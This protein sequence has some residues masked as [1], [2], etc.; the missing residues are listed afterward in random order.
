MGGGS[1][2][3]VRSDEER[4]LL[5]KEEGSTVVDEVEPASVGLMTLFG[6]GAVLFGM[7]GTSLPGMLQGTLYGD[8]DW[9]GKQ[10]K[11]MIV[12]H[13]VGLIVCLGTGTMLLPKLKA[14]AEEVK[15]KS[16]TSSSGVE[17]RWDTLKWTLTM[18]VSLTHFTDVF[19]AYVWR[20]IYGTFKEFFLME[21]YMFVSGYLSNPNPTR[22]R[23]RAIWKSVVGAYVVNQIFFLLLVKIAYKWGPADR[24]YVT[25]KAYTP[26]EAAKLN[27]FYEFWMPFSI[28]YYLADLIMARIV[29]PTWVELRYPLA[30]SF[31][32]AVCIQY[33]PWQDQP[34]FFAMV[35]FFS[36]FPYYMLGVTI[37]KHSKVFSRI[38]DWH[39]TRIALAVSFLAF[40]SLT[41]VS[42]GLRND[43]GFYAKLEKGGWYDAYQGKEGFAYNSLYSGKGLWVAFY[44]TIGGIPLRLVMIFAAISLFG[45]GNDEV[46]LFGGRLNITR[47]GKN[48]MANYII[49]YYAKFLLAFTTLFEPTHYS[50]WKVIGIFALVFVQANVWMYPPVH[51]ILKPIFLAPNVDALL[52]DEDKPPPPA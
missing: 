16:S 35:E 26:S 8:D 41:V 2:A 15:R 42:Y 12:L 45:V 14:V 29:A 51:R 48:S 50:P 22:R 25:F 1:R 21:S 27:L 37:R 30:F 31:V 52:S 43:L 33:I 38:L 28:L 39:S 34:T 3:G 20:Q 7:S 36:F 13:V 17:H 44:D 19:S 49:H 18:L 5:P 6:L 11:L 4:S 32:L 10:L 24:L 9:Y 47:Q 40:F 46:V 23:L